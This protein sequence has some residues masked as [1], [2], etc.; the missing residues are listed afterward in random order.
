MRY[1]QRRSPLPASTF[2]GGEYRRIFSLLL[3]LMVLGMMYRYARNPDTWLWLAAPDEKEAVEEE[4]APPPAPPAGKP[5]VKAAGGVV[6][7]PTDQTPGQ[8]EEARR[9]FQAL[10][11]RQPFTGME[12]SAY[13]ML[14]RWSRAQTFAEMDARAQKE[15]FFT[16]YFEEP[17][18]H[19]G[20]LLR[21]RVHIK[22]IVDNKAPKNSANVPVVYEYWAWTDESK[23]YPYCLLS[24]ELPEGWKPGSEVTQEGVFVG[25]F[26]KTLGYTAFDKNRFAPVL[27]GKIKPVKRRGAGGGAALAPN[28]NWRDPWLIAAGGA[29]LAAGAWFWLRRPKSQPVGAPIDDAQVESW[30]AKGDPIIPNSGDKPLG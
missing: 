27:I 1:Y 8:M 25:Y 18:E 3:A 7:G 4:P 19:R 17:D 2:A 5:A 24:D 29:L 26:L 22:R 12:M 30:L 13:W 20:K 11:D 15:I 23:S 14:F 6:E 28:F 9:L 10:T 21:L 16:R